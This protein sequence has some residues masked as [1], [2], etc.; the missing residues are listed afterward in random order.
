MLLD[1]YLCVTVKIRQI[2]WCIGSCGTNISVIMTESNVKMTSVELQ[3][4]NCSTQTLVK[5][6]GRKRNRKYAVKK[7]IVEDKIKFPAE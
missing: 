5:I 7:L 4:L 2:Q 1:V 6:V 3:I